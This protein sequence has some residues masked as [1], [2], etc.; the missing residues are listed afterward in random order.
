MYG[1]VFISHSKDDPNLD[2]F[3]KVFSA[4]QT[5]AVWMEFEEIEAPPYISIRDNVNRSDAVFVLLSEHL[6]SRQYTNNWVSFEVGLAANFKRLKVSPKATQARLGLDV[7]VF[8]P[9]DRNISFAVPYCT[10]YM[11][12]EPNLPTL[13]RLRL[14]LEEAP[15][16]VLGVPAT[17]HWDGCKL[18]FNYL[19]RSY[20]KPFNCP[21]CR[22]IMQVPKYWF[23]DYAVERSWRIRKRGKGHDKKSTET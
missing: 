8:E 6:V 17:C 10:Y 11:R 14:A 1:A 22:G 21:A 9:L 15:S 12:Y 13:K 16:H 4:V 2:F 19:T 20:E 5:K 7:W 23:Y 3:H 18:S